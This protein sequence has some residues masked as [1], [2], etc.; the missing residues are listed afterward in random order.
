MYPDGGGE[1]VV[2]CPAVRRMKPLRLLDNNS[3]VKRVRGLVYPY[4]H[5]QTRA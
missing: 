3:K 4:S 2:S 5:K 1:V